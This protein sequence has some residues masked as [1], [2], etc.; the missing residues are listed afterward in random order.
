MIKK[1]GLC[2]S[3]LILSN[4]LHAGGMINV[5][6]RFSVDETAQ[7]L[8]SILKSKGMTVFAQIDHSDGAKKADLSLPPTQLVIFGN[9]KVGTPLMLCQR[10]VAIDLPQKALIW[11]DEN[12]NVWFSYNDPEYLVERHQLSGD[13]L[14]VIKKVKGA[15]STF[16][17]LATQEK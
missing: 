13:C 5:Q 4:W 9:P 3:L 17:T 10:S 12:Q 16:S 6:S 15:L 1:I 7:R 11:Q 8:V 2:L 14:N